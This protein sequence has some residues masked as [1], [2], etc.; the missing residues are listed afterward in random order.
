MVDLVERYVHQVGRYLPPKERADIEAELRSMIQDQLDDRF[1]SAPTQSDVEVV[2]SELGDP[3]KMAISYGSHQY[4]VGPELYPFM[5]MVLRRGLYIIPAIAIFVSIFE[6]ITLLPEGGSSWLSLAF[7]IAFGAIQAAL[8]FTG[9]VVGIFALVQYTGTEIKELDKPFS[10]ADLPEIDDPAAVN[11]FEIL[12]GVT[13]GAF[14]ILVLLYFLRVG[15]LTLTFNPTDPGAVIPVPT[16]WLVVLLINTLI[17]I[18]LNLLMLWR[19]RW[20]VKTWILETALELIGMVALYF[21]L[22]EPVLERLLV[23]VPTLNNIPLINSVPEIIVIVGA[24]ITLAVRGS[25]L[26]SIMT[27]QSNDRPHQP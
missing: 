5:M 24:V 6:I 18:T 10:P 11:R 7:E 21:V 17:I 16:V 20:G 13:F 9:V 15:G 12:F 22:Y 27:Y 8:V 2:L 1:G 14:F 19:K 25:T 3:R 23:A 26:V 4:L